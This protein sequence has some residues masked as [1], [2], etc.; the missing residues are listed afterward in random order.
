MIGYDDGCQRKCT[1]EAALAFSS[2]EAFSK[3][4]MREELTATIL[5][6]RK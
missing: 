3:Q 5:C 6:S 1:G 4:D 2:R